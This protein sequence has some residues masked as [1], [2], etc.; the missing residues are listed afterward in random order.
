MDGVDLLE[1]GVDETD[2]SSAVAVVET[3]RM[4]EE[5]QTLGDAA[6][7]LNDTTI[8]LQLSELDQVVRGVYGLFKSDDDP[9]ATPSGAARSHARQ[10]LSSRN[11]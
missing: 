11:R 7:A 8:E 6:A 10:F 9:S 2:L 5:G 4:L 3:L 1:G